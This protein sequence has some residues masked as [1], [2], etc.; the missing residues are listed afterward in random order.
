MEYI[1]YVYVNYRDHDLDKTFFLSLKLKTLI[2]HIYDSCE[3]NL[4]L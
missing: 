4:Q 3:H 2:F 1:C